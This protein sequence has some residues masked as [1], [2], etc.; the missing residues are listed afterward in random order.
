MN[1]K[2]RIKELKRLI[3][4][5][6][7]LAKDNVNNKHNLSTSQRQSWVDELIELQEQDN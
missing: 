1:T 3:S 2:E 6:D 5:W 4:I 7:Q